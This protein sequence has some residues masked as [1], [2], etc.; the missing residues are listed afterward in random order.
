MGGRSGGVKAIVVDDEPAMHLIMS[1]ML[2]KL[3]GIQV[4]GT[5]LDTQTAIFL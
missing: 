1:K 5:F 3:P 2:A 4:A